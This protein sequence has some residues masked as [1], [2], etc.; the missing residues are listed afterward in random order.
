MLRIIGALLAEISEN[1]Q[2]KIYFDMGDYHEW[3]RA[4]P[5]RKAEWVNRFHP[6]LGPISWQDPR[7]N[8]IG[9][10]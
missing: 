1:W 10:A 6:K 3:M 2:E 7:Y 4:M 8:R 5:Q 9:K